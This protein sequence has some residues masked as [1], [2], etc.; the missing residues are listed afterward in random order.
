MHDVAGVDLAEADAAVERRRDGRVGKLRLRRLDRGLVRL[1][2]R[3]ELVDLGLL[4]V[5]ALLGR[6]VLLRQLL[7]A[8]EVLLRG[9]ELGLVLRLLRHRLIERGLQRPRI[10]LG[11]DVLPWDNSAGTAGGGTAV[12]VAGGAPGGV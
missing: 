1:D 8:G 6:E 11:Q 4:L 9:D 7:E 2:R 3:L 10:D 5:D 12:V